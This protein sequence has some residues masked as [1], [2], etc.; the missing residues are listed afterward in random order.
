MKKYI[1]NIL[2]KEDELCTGKG[3]LASARSYE[4]E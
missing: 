4:F 3:R 2:A 1:V